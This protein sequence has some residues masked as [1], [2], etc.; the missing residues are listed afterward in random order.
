MIK[1]VIQC[2]TGL[3]GSSYYSTKSEA[4]QA[5]KW[6]E[7]CTGLQWFVREILIRQP[8]VAA[9]IRYLSRVAFL[10]KVIVKLS[11]RTIKFT[12]S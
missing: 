6:R 12:N 4:G 2:E 7:L 11:V 8:L 9:R 10:Y 1:Y 3:Q 5:A